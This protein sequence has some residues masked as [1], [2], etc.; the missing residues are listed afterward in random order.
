MVV[1]KNNNARIRQRRAWT[2]EE[3]TSDYTN[4][5]AFRR[6][7]NLGVLEHTHKSLVV[8]LCCGLSKE[9]EVF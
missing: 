6:Y 4:I 9:V 2:F 5:R 1:A 3:S 7:P 8:A